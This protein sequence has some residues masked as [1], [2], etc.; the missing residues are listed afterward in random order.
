MK[1]IEN[2]H[3]FTEIST[4][5]A[6]DISGGGLLTAAAFASLAPYFNFTT[7]EIRS[8]SFLFLINALPVPGF[9]SSDLIISSS[10]NTTMFRSHRASSG[11]SLFLTQLLYNVEP[12]L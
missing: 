2:S 7:P 11:T 3:I 1:D 6:A 4:E 12:W 9:L 10:S 8:I 5:E